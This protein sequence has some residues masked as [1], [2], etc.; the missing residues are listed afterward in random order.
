MDT[1][2]ENAAELDRSRYFRF[3][4]ELETLARHVDA[5][6]TASGYSATD[7]DGGRRAAVRRLRELADRLEGSS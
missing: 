5:L 3:A 2:T 6:A 4:R 1:M 7:L